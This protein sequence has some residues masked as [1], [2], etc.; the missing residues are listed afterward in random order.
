M[1]LLDYKR[2]ELK[3][4]DHRPVT[5]V[6]MAE[7]EVFCHRKLQK[8]LTLTDAEVEDGG[9]MPDVD[10]TLEMGLG[11]VSFLFP[12]KL[13]IQKRIDF[14]NDVCQKSKI[15]SCH[16]VFVSKVNETIETDASVSHVQTV[17]PTGLVAGYLRMAAVD[18]RVSATCGC[19][20]SRPSS[21]PSSTPTVRLRALL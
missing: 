1:R 21:W 11:D 15:L 4:S 19:F 6:F 13:R 12:C 16:F 17:L 5:A 18:R 14:P 8:A 2:A 10:F 3:L 9:T 20:G 7:V